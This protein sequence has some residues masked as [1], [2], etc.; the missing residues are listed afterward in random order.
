M[1]ANTYAGLVVDLAINVLLK[2]TLILGAAGL[3][4]Y[5]LRGTSA[6][7]RHAVWSLALLALLVLP[8]LEA[9]L[10]SW[11]VE[12]LY[13]TVSS[14]TE[15]VQPGTDFTAGS[16][17][18][19]CECT[20]NCDESDAAAAARYAGSRAGP[21]DEAG[22]IPVTANDSADPESA[23]S[24]GGASTA[25]YL[26]F[27][28]LLGAGMLLVRFAIDGFRVMAMTERA[29]HASAD[30]S[31]LAHHLAASL[32]IRRRVRLVVSDEL[33]VPVTF[34]V[35]FPVVML[36]SAANAWSAERKRVVLLHELAH[37]SRWDYAIHVMI[38]VVC[39]LYWFNPVVWLAARLSNLEQERAC[40][41]QALVGGVRSDVYAT[42]LV[43]IARS[44]VDTTPRGAFAMAHPSS[45][46]SRVK[47]ILARG[48]DRAPISQRQLLHL[49]VGAVS[50][51]FPLASVDLWGVLQEEKAGSSVELR[52][53]QLQ[54][55]DAEVRRFA[56]WA[57]GELESSQGV[58]P[59][60]DALSDRNADLRL[61]SAWALGEIKDNDA[62]E[63][64]IE[65]L[66]DKDPFVGE[67]AVLALG[68]TG[69]TR[70]I[71]AIMKAVEHDEGLREPA[72]WALYQ[73]GG[74]RAHDARQRLFEHHGELSWDSEE[75]WTGYLGTRKAQS[76]GL[77]VPALIDALDDKDAALRTSAAEYLGQRGDPRAVEALLDT[78]RDRDPSVR[79]M[80]I[81]ALDE[82]NPS[83]GY[84][85]R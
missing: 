39:A 73:I 13:V 63:P 79:A 10:P 49:T 25:A 70:A 3:A 72:V 30:D 43:E 27:L 69:S 2:G 22:A 16:Y 41:D 68:E 78:L 55:G 80:A 61:V 75:V 36:P 12:P 46:A 67:M 51:A 29:E 28:W 20:C 26:L 19:D 66:D 77:D 65:L 58:D 37:V 17:G 45:L 4:T 76:I 21:G 60:V 54:K 62:V 84:S 81:W 85:S 8:V 1:L 74:Q 31:A 23:K 64:L 5:L 9:A 6:A 33:S 35:W 24:A 40:D 50:I 7:M 38:V 18:E 34:G 11:K 53:Q 59:L 15:S 48:L 52:V 42:H 56:A 82:I 57:L 14:Q 83:R 32:G 44:V 47:S 71:D